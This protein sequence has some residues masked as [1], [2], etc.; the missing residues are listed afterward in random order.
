[1]KRL[2]SLLIVGILVLSLPICAM[3]SAVTVGDLAKEFVSEAYSDSAE[4]SAD[5]SWY[6]TV[7]GKL[8]FHMDFEENNNGGTVTSDAC[9]DM[10]GQPSSNGKS[11]T[12]FG[13]VN[14]NV[15]SAASSLYN[16]SFRYVDGVSIGSEGS[17]NFIQVSTLE[18]TYV[19]MYFGNVFTETGTY[20]ID[21]K[22]KYVPDSSST[23]HFYYLERKTPAGDAISDMVT[24]EWTDMSI[25]YDVTAAT[26]IRLNFTT[27]DGTVYSTND[28]F[29]IDDVKIYKYEEPPVEEDPTVSTKW[30]DIDKGNLLFNAGFDTNNEGGSVTSDACTDMI[31]TPSSNGKLMSLFGEVNPY[32][33]TSDYNMSFRY[34]DGVSIGSEGDNQFMQVSTLENT[35][36]SMYF[37]NVF[38][39]A[40]TYTIEFKYKY[41]P[42]SSSSAYFYYL[43][44]KIPADDAIGEMV[45]GEW[46]DM[47]LTYEVTDA[48]DIRLNF[49]TKDGTL[50]STNDMFLIDDIKV[51]KMGDAF[52]G[53]LDE[54]EEE[55]PTVSTKWYN[56]DKGN[57]L[58]NA[59][60]ATNNY[61]GSVTADVC[62][63]M[64]GTP[65]SNGKLMS[66]FGEVNPYA[67]TSNYSMSFRYAD[68]VSI[69][70]EGDNSFMQVSAVEHTFVSLYFGNVFTE[71]AT[72]T[73]EFKY[74][75]VPDSSSS[76]YFYYLERKIPADDAIGEMVT[77]EW[78]DMSL[79]YEVTDATDIRLNFTTKDGTLYSTNDMFLIDDIKVYKM[80][81]AFEGS[82]DEPE[83]EV[84]EEPEVVIETVNVTVM[85]GE[86]T[87]AGD[88]VIA[89]PKGDITIDNL[90]AY[91]V[92]HGDMILRGLSY[93]DGGE[94]I[95]GTLTLTEDMTVYAH[96]QKTGEIL[97]EYSVEFE[98]DESSGNDIMWNYVGGNASTVTGH[99]YS[100]HKDGYG[101]LT[102]NAV[103]DHIG[104]WDSN[105]RVTN[106]AGKI[107]E[108]GKIKGIMIR[109]R[110]RN[111]PTF[112]CNCK[113][114]K[115]NHTFQYDS[116]SG[117]AKDVVYTNNRHMFQIYYLNNSADALSENQSLRLRYNVYG[118]E[119]MNQEWFTLYFDV[120][121]NADFQ[122]KDIA[123]MRFDFEN[124]IWD[125][126]IID[127]DYIRLIGDKSYAPETVDVNEI[128]TTKPMGIR[129]MA[130][131]TKE[132]QDSA[133]SYGWIFAR[134]TAL[135]ASSIE[136]K[137][138]TYEAATEAGVATLRGV[139]FKE[140]RDEALIYNEDGAN[141]YFTALLYNIP[142]SGYTDKIVARPFAVVG[143]L[144]YYGDYIT[145]SMY[146][147][148]LAI[149]ADGFRGH[150][151]AQQSYIQRVID[152]VEEN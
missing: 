60:F 144:V 26:D 136:N 4:L 127:L 79:T 9:T 52:E 108:K 54:S 125:N 145:K 70:S 97:D 17:N 66:L 148:A 93:Q 3:P 42:D 131:L 27:K 32:A 84:P 95:T 11:A 37:G 83:E 102:F 86:N 64:I 100:R 90:K 130:S 1:M 61:G 22:Y 46:T 132:I 28:M 141:I 92:D 117:T 115:H 16:M 44:R 68:G 73:I 152:I 116:S 147:V 142:Q 151:A 119:I 55:K 118:T 65:S 21:F 128:K 123:H 53:S 29:F 7:K 5:T 126:M 33:P 91:V 134:E 107:I 56:I 103:N 14:P 82:L 149:K 6:D 137:E 23:A 124:G 140:G 133:T 24:G 34:V 30:Y 138:F 62:T 41:V 89:V 12:G 111:I 15:D 38:T 45:T 113:T 99:G 57:L 98:F 94:L 77:G 88:K 47:S 101:S 19:S 110:Y 75:Y 36:V 112:T 18:N 87:I 129:F 146:D 122:E 80:G 40:A 25:T 150:T 50:Y 139:N 120:S 10:I 143:D 49:T 135:N 121:Q 31:G 39:E 51:Y 109:M 104:I 48:T 71:A 43:E 2:L 67:P 74:K 72:Y 20:T 106:Q 96:W 13:K 76:A 63:D 78:T 69:G 81:D 114:D 85:G 105:I 58:F 8:L 35:Y 59:G